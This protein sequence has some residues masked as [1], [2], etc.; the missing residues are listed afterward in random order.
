[1]SGTKCQVTLNAIA[2]QNAFKV[3]GDRWVPLK[4]TTTAFSNVFA[5]AAQPD[6]QTVTLPSSC[7]KM[8]DRVQ[9]LQASAVNSLDRSVNKDSIMVEQTLRSLGYR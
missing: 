4:Q 2:D 5:K 6:L 1:M 3:Q 9:T 7:E 8:R